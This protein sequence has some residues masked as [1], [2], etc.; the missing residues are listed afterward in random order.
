M[1]EERGGA[2]MESLTCPTGTLPSSPTRTGVCWLKTK[3]HQGQAGAGRKT[4]RLFGQGLRTG[5]PGG[6]A[7]F[8]VELVVIDMRQQLV[9]Q[10]V[11]VLGSQ[12][13][14]GGEEGWEAPLV[15]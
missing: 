3:G 13:V 10:R 4:E 5:S 9:E 12:D 11:G 15:V 2:S 7:Q 14:I 6:H 8:P 1:T